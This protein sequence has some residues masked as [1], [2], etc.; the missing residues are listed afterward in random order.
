MK[1]QRK[2]ITS[3]TNPGHTTRYIAL[4]LLGWVVSALLLGGG[5]WLIWQALFR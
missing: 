2:A 5:F 3:D 4:A 1:I